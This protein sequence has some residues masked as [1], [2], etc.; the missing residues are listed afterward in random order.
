MI[1]IYDLKQPSQLRMP[2]ICIFLSIRQI[3]SLQKS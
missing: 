3:L 2:D 1:Q